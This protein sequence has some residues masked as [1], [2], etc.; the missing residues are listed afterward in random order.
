MR[1]DQRLSIA[2]HAVLHIAEAREPATSE[3]LAARM[4][5]HPV[6]LRRTLGGLRDAGI[7]R[8][9]K[10]HGGGWT[11]GRA[12]EAVTLAEVYA[13]LGVTSLF[14]VGNRFERPRCMLEQAINRVTTSAL[15]DA[16]ALFV[17]RL[18]EVRLSDLLAEARKKLRTAHAKGRAHE[19]KS[20]HA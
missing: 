16:E 12:L 7:V 8:A 6:V 9:E 11:I 13:A 2:L 5:V 3:Q 17:E 4:E 14:A 1:R 18:T 19:R 20:S 15:G 10:G